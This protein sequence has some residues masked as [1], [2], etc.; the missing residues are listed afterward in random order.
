MCC[1]AIPDNQRERMTLRA[2][3][4]AIDGLR[5]RGAFLPPR[6]PGVGWQECWREC[7]ETKRG[8]CCARK[9]PERTEFAGDRAPPQ[10]APVHG[11]MA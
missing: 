9:K 7:S 2:L 1:E 11:A 3:K 10:T 5:P 4:T 8:R 6:M